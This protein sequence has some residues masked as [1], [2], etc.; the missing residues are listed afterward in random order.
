MADDFI[1]CSRCEK[2]AWMGNIK[3][4]EYCGEYFCNDCDVCKDENDCDTPKNKSE[5]II[6]ELKDEII[7]L[8]NE[9]KKLKA[10]TKL[11]IAKN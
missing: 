9:I 10:K 5:M 6:Q 11:K 2:L 7:K 4:C 1:N 3:H 8:K